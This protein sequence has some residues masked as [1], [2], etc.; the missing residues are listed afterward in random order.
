MNE[1]SFICIKINSWFQYDKILPALFSIKRFFLSIIFFYYHSFQQLTFFLIWSNQTKVSS[2]FLSIIDLIHISILTADL[3][4]SNED[5]VSSHFYYQFIQ[6]KF[7]FFS[8][9][10]ILRKQ[11]YMKIFD[12]FHIEEYFYLFFFM[13]W[14]LNFILIHSINGINKWSILIIYSFMK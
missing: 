11:R 8:A 13:D 6:I 14:I 10:R 9:E 3:S 12:D 2:A 7:E 5:L 4:K 1:N